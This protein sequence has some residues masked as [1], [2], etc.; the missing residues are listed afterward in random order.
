MEKMETEV[1]KQIRMTKIQ[2]GILT[3]VYAAGMISVA[4]L[5]P[6]VLRVIQSVSKKSGL[7]DKVTRGK[8]Q[9]INVSRKRLIEAGLLIYKDGFLRLTKRGEDKMREFEARNFELEKPRR[10]DGKW[11]VLIFDI[12]ES[13]KYVRD[14]VR[15]TLRSVGFIRLQNSVWVYPYDCEDLVTMFKADMKIGKDLLYIIADKIENDN[16]AREHF[17]L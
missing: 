6:N 12:K 3:A 13:R 15:Y 16:F 5:A 2:N 14:K 10:W 8:K 7:Y 11:R 4:L 1:K 17:K 9:S